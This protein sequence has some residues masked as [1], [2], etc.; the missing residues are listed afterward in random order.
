MAWK[1]LKMFNA[2]GFTNPYTYI[3]IA[4]KNNKT[5]EQEQIEKGNGCQE[6][7]RCQRENR[8][9]QKRQRENHFNYRSVEWRNMFQ[10]TQVQVLGS[11][12]R[13]TTKR[14]LLSI[15]K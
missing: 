7:N 11:T 14:H 4:Q 5:H 9:G 1:S 12:S 15:W 2:F 6:G 3:C 10:C 8:K 13:I